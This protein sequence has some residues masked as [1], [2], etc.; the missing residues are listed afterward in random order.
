M[1]NRGQRWSSVSDTRC[2]GVE[3]E[4]LS[5]RDGCLSKTVVAG[6]SRD[7]LQKISALVVQSLRNDDTS[8]AVSKEDN[9]YTGYN[10]GAGKGAVDDELRKL[11]EEM[12]RMSQRMRLIEIGSIEATYQAGRAMLVETLRGLINMVDSRESGESCFQ[13]WDPFF[14]EGRY[15]TYDRTVV[16]TPALGHWLFKGPFCDMIKAYGVWKTSPPPAGIRASRGVPLEL[17]LPTDKFPG[18]VHLTKRENRAL[19]RLVNN[20]SD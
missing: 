6:L 17:S 13:E 19:V 20:K 8:P 3:S 14:F 16:K 1:A 5:S 2:C 15:D 18:Y 10:I 11:R 7:D 9:S 4:A 12:R